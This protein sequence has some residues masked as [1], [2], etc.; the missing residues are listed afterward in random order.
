MSE[1]PVDPG[2]IP[3]YAYPP[4]VVPDYDAQAQRIAAVLQEAWDRVE[5][6]KERLFALVEGDA[7][8]PRIKARLDE[9]QA[10]IRRFQA[11]AADE[12]AHLV[13]LVT[14]QYANGM[15]LAAATAG[16]AVS[17]TPAHQQVVALLAADTYSD[18]LER[19]YEAGRV[20][21]RLVRTIRRVAREEM[22]FQATGGKTARDVGRAIRARLEDEFRIG[23]VTYRDGSI[24]SVREYTEMLARTKGRVAQNSG[25][26]NAYFEIGIEY[27]EV[28]DGGTCGWTSHQDVDKA[29]GTIRTAEACAAQLLSHPNCRRT[30]GP[31]PDVTAANARAA[32]PLQDLQPYIDEAYELA[33]LEDAV[34]AG[35]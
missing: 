16:F 14:G 21:D 32:K 22:P 1:Q 3:G 6:E 5:A 15:V 12:A 28:F 20:S 19:S 33:V 2:G 9:Y 35:L 27:L 17:W 7:R 11:V 8:W 13:T 25:S 10:E 31:R 26:V 23:T 4:R 29:N 30:F 34:R 18:L 24:H